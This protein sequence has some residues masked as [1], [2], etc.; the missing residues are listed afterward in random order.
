MTNVK[1]KID[2]IKS[3]LFLLLSG[4]ATCLFVP[5]MT[6]ADGPGLGDL[7]IKD[8]NVT[9]DN[10]IGSLDEAGEKIKET[11]MNVVSWVMII[12]LIITVIGMVIAGVTFA[13]SQG[14]PQKRAQAKTAFVG[15]LI[16]AAVIG[17]AI[18][19]TNLA[20]GMFQNL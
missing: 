2:L 4:M 9:W 5:T 14:N 7:T 6:Y 18:F 8:G 19:L 11:G 10:G 17:G 15:C 13:M 3:K 16:G 20:F 12:G 1:N